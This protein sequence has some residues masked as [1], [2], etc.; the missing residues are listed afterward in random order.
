MNSY[1]YHQQCHYNDLIS[2][3]D[4]LTVE[5]GQESI[6]NILANHDQLTADLLDYQL[7]FMGSIDYEN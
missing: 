4:D 1:N 5:F 7:D 6:Q 3:I 2:F